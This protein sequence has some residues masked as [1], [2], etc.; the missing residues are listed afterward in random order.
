MR[1]VWVNRYIPDLLVF[2]CLLGVRWCI[3]DD[4]T[5]ALLFV[6]RFLRVV[7]LI[8]ARLTGILLPRLW[9]RKYC[10]NERYLCLLWH[11]LRDMWD[12]LHQE[13]KWSQWDLLIVLQHT[14]KQPQTAQPVATGLV[15]INRVFRQQGGQLVISPTSS[16]WRRLNFVVMFLRSSSNHDS[17]IFH[18]D[19]EVIS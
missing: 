16:S 6:L 17:T 13:L 9:I 5:S 3:V 18:D 8:S 12:H 1:V 14:C 11:W 7:Q 4:R 19:S 2:G 10:Y 15:D